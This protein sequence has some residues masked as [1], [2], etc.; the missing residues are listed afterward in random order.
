MLAT[1][2]GRL[3]SLIEG[4]DQAVAS[5]SLTELAGDV[6]REPQ[7]RGEVDVEAASNLWAVA[8]T[9][10]VAEALRQLLAGGRQAGVTGPLIV[11]GRQDGDWVGLSMDV[12]DGPRVPTGLTVAIHVAARLMQDQG[13]E[14]RLEARAGGGASIG[15]WLPSAVD[16]AGGVGDRCA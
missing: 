7:W 9:A 11:R 13:G 14:V 5:I 1:G 6:A 15:I 2:V 3:R 8:S 16:E 12:G 10:I 4:G